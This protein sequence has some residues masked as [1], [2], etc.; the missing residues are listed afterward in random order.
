MQ[1]GIYDNI[2]NKPGILLETTAITNV[3]TNSGWQNVNLTTPLDLMS[4]TTIWIAWMYQNSSGTRRY[5]AVSGSTGYVT[6]NGTWS[7][8]GSN[9]P[10]SFGS[11]TTT[12]GI[13]FSIYANYE[14]NA[15]ACPKRSDVNNKLVEVQNYINQNGYNFTVGI[16]SVS[17]IPLEKLC[18][19]IP[20]IDGNVQ[21]NPEQYQPITLPS[22]FSWQNYM[23][24]I[25][26]QGNWGTCWAFAT[27]GSYE[28][29]L[30][31]KHNDIEDLSEQYLVSCN[32]FNYDGDPVKGGGN[33]DFYDIKNGIPKELDY[34]YIM[35]SSKP[36]C[37]DTHAKYYPIDDYYYVG[38]NNIDAIK[39][40]IYLYGPVF[41]SIHIDDAFPCY[42]G[43][44]YTGRNG[45]ENHGIVI[46]G[47]DDSKDAW[48]IKN[49]WGTDW[50]ENGYAWFKYNTGNIGNNCFYG[51][52]LVAA[53]IPQNPHITAINATS[54]TGEWNVVDN[55]TSYTVQIYQNNNWVVAGTVYDNIYYFTGTPNQTLKWRVCSNKTGIGQTKSSDYSVSCQHIFADYDNIKFMKWTFGQDPNNIC[56]GW[57]ASNGAQANPTLGID[58]IYYT[59]QMGECS[60][61]TSLTKNL[62]IYE[63]EVSK[64]CDFIMISKGS[65]YFEGFSRILVHFTNGTTL[66]FSKGSNNN[67][68]FLLNGNSKVYSKSTTNG[69]TTHCFNFS[70]ARPTNVGISSI[71]IVE[72]L[73]LGINTCM[74]TQYTNYRQ[75]CS[76]QILKSPQ[77]DFNSN[78]QTGIIPLSVHFTSSQD[79]DVFTGWEWS[80]GDGTKSLE[81]NPTHLYINRGVYNVNLKATWLGGT[82]N[83]QR[84]NYICVFNPCPAIDF[85]A[86]KTDGCKPLTVEFKAFNCG[87]PVNYWVWNFGDGTTLNTTSI[88]INHTYTEKG[89]YTVKLEAFGD[90]HVEEIKNNY[91]KVKPS[92][93]SP[94][95]E[96]LLD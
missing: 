36:P 18:G 41:A 96:L 78:L 66:E 25:K 54:A 22:V 34:P 27:L 13:D 63:S 71:E 70:G 38:S 31:I 60:K 80:F 30:N 1:F 83:L 33:Q 26:D 49:S 67:D 32:S 43:G 29:H 10:A 65:T 74:G 90:G 28:A 35:T 47:W 86:N 3:E 91:I 81:R 94:I 39:Q 20:S 48:R 21:L 19:V 58:L 92:N 8:S 76:V 69:I 95:L 55:A 6:G 84:D 42:T 23:T 93:L 4:G 9:M 88:T 11:V 17:N 75:Y 40:T 37:D 7:T 79:V 44:V 5:G 14:P 56:C 24:P 73:W 46:C 72:N 50:G 51:V 12:T 59:Y 77:I 15:Y 53:S 45:R 87:G 57:N 62:T 64:K 85:A 2:N 16:T 82:S 52:S 61:G 89:T 68:L